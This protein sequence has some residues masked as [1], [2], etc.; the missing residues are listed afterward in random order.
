MTP[1]TTPL[2]EG[3]APAPERL[4]RSRKW[5]VYAERAAGS[6]CPEAGALAELVHRPRTA[7]SAFDTNP[8][9]DPVDVNPFQVELPTHSSH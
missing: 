1:R 4:P 3:T 7:M 5:R 8:F 2:G 9:A 6:A